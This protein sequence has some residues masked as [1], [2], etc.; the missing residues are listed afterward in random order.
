MNG[1]ELLL[2]RNVLRDRLMEYC[3]K[4]N[5]LTGGY[6]NR[7]NKLRKRRDPAFRATVY[8]RTR[9]YLAV[10]RNRSG[11]AS[12]SKKTADLLGC[13]VAEL[14]SHLEARFLPGM[15]WENYGRIWHI[16]HIKPCAAFDL[17][18]ADQQ[19]KCFNYSNLQPLFA[20][21]N[22]RKGKRFHEDKTD[23]QKERVEE[24]SAPLPPL[25]V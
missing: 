20:I 7:Y 19:R 17:S 1:S 5:Q 24:A 14:M 9:I 4:K 23:S 12:K 11:M 15:C 6:W 2:E 13:T 10:K 21:D 18:S 16:D 25:A 22:I 3:R 8:L